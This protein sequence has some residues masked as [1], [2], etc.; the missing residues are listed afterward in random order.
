[1]GLYDAALAD[2]TPATE[3]L[4][5]P[6]QA[7]LLSPRFIFK[8]EEDRP[9]TT[10]LDGYEIATRLSYLLWSTMPDEALLAAAAG[11]ELD[12][13]AGIPAQVRRM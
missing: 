4:A 7:A 3:A 6:L 11:G 1:M 12:T 10:R 13:T 9:N 2:G 8:V 5:L